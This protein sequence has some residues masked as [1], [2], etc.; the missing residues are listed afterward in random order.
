MKLKICIVILFSFVCICILGFEQFFFIKHSQERHLSY[1]SLPYF[2][3]KDTLDDFYGGCAHLTSHR[4]CP[5]RDRELEMMCSLGITNVRYDFQ[6]D[7]IIKTNKGF[8]YRRLDSVMQSLRYHNINSL[9]IL[10][11]N[12]SL[13][14][15]DNPS[16]YRQKLSFLLDKC[17]GIVNDWEFLNEIN[18]I[19]EHNI[20]IRYLN[21]LKWLFAFIKR[22]DSNNRVVFSGLSSLSS[23]SFLE[24]IGSKKA[25]NYFDV[26]NFHT[27]SEPEKLNEC[28]VMLK[29]SMNRY[30]WSRPVWLT[31]CGMHTACDEKDN[32]LFFR[33]ILPQALAKLKISSNSTVAVIRDDENG[34]WSLG[35]AEINNFLKDTFSE[36]YYCPLAQ[37]DQLNPKKVPVLIAQRDEE[38]PMKYLEGLIQYVRNGGTIVFPEKCP[39]YYDIDKNGRREQIGDKYY[40]KLHMSALFP[41]SIEGRIKGIPNKISNLHFSRDFKGKISP[42]LYKDSSLRYMSDKNLKKGDKLIPILDCDN[43]CGLACI[44]GIYMLNSDL[45]GNIIFSTLMNTH[46][47][48]TEEEQAKRVARYYLL[49]LSYGVEKV[50]W[51]NVRARETEISDPEAN[52]GLLHKN[53]APKPAFF[54]YKTLSEMLPEK[55][56]RPKLVITDNL[57]ECNWIKPDGTHVKAVW[58]PAG[59]KEYLIKEKFICY[60]YTGDIIEYMDVVDTGVKYFVEQ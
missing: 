56:T 48:N 11:Q 20:E 28:F 31:E 13:R 32:S 19:N 4:D 52:F 22:K 26:M 33:V 41:W 6:W 49:A 2:D 44:A 7:H 40:S 53:L 24:L 58:C 5:L 27:Y 47:I 15:W 59:E 55:S 45:K 16:D 39:L 46:P 25:Y 50:F 57:Y 14:V 54:A 21:A 38:F 51:Y 35:F 9:G 29:E 42:N 18:G 43:S 17:K 10:G 36:I 37:L 8:S 60:N 1:M 23:N 3:C 34:Y 12:D 30:G